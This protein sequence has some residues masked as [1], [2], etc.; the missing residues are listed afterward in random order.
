M[1]LRG[2]LF[3]YSMRLIWKLAK[4]KTQDLKKVRRD[5]HFWAQFMPPTLGVKRKKLKIDKL[6]AEWVIPR[7]A[8]N[9]QVLLFLHGGA[10]AMCSIRT[11][12][13]LVSKIAKAAKVK[14][15]LIDYCLAPEEVF[16]EALNQ[17]CDAYK[18]L[19]QEGYKPEN[20]TIGGDS[21]G[22]GLTVS[23][24]MKL[25]DDKVPLPRAA[26]LLSP[27]TD[28]EGTGES[29]KKGDQQNFINNESLRLYGKLYAGDTDIR[30]P[31]V[32]PI[33]GDFQG[34]PPMLIH[35]G[36]EE[37]IY[38]DSARLYTKA[39]AAGVDVTLEP[40]A[41]MV[42]VWHVYDFL[43]PEGERAIK[44]LG[45]YLREQLDKPVPQT[46]ANKNIAA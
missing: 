24:L 26:I 28:L 9:D 46:S 33:Y 3:K 25:R 10:F 17:A 29:H 39:L 4:H 5:I 44:S 36:A 16:P 19:L 1:S 6:P 21:A 14:A 35:V 15:L 7:R 8:K 23:T 11:H 41:D 45:K 22:G 30:H 20:I 18:W 31:L 13:R 38:D 40:W 43:I 2:K 42:H 27:W 34:L 32:S 37:L 12:R